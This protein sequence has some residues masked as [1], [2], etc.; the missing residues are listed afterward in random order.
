MTMAPVTRASKHLAVTNTAA[1]FESVLSRDVRYLYV[2]T[3]PSWIK[4]ANGAQIAAYKDFADVDEGDLDTIIEA[5][6]PGIAGDDIAVS[7]VGD[8]DALTPATTI[9]TAAANF[10][11]ANAI[12]TLT[13]T[14]QPVDT[15]TVTINGTI[16]TFLTILIDAPGNVL[17]GSDEED[18]LVNLRLAVT[19]GAGA[20]TKYGTGT[21]AHATV[22]LAD[23]AGTTSLATAKSPGTGGNALTA[24]TTVTGA[25]WTA[26]TFAGGATPGQVVIGAKTYRGVNY[27]AAANDILIGASA[28]ASL[29]NLDAAI[30][31]GAG[32]GTLY[33]AG[34]T[35]N[36]QVTSAAGAGDTLDI[37]A[38]TGGAA[39]NA[40]AT[41]T[42][43]AGWSFTG[44]T[45][46]GGLDSEGATI[47]ED[48]DDKTVIIH[49]AIGETTVEDV[50][51][52]IDA[53]ATL[54]QV[55]TAG[56]GVT[57]LDADSAF[58]A[59]NLEHGGEGADNAEPTATAGDGSM[60]VPASVVLVLDG[61]LGDTVSVLRSGG[62]NGD[63]SLT[64]AR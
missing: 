31:A 53:D 48:T 29:D 24:S 50:E 22:S 41:T 13:F 54:I 35:A 9:L 3:I 2:C 14:G 59:T 12:N 44:T 46:A 34:T 6:L 27:L 62:S 10:V 42:T 58:T 30:D 49:Y 57:V 61:R 52:A 60:F 1:Q 21:T 55:K 4:Q 37:T 7:M 63:A 16:Y 47:E 28:S 23:A 36:A 17:I 11:R 32:S 43:V 26:G 40:V 45:L 20:G 38:D 64:P 51:D 39:G 18:S 33:G 56:T 8:N 15:Q 19:A 5:A 25:S